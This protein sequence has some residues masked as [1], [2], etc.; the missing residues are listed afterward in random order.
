VDK[1]TNGAFGVMDVK[2]DRNREEVGYNRQNKRQ[3]DETDEKAR[4]A[5]E[6][7]KQTRWVDS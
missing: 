4:K 2:N 6:K 1:E 7:K 5:L 3:A